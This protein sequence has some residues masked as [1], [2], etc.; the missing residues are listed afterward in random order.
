MATVW[1]F[2]QFTETLRDRVGVSLRRGAALGE[3]SLC[4]SPQ[5][6]ENLRMAAIDASTAIADHPYE[7]KSV[8][9]KFQSVL[10]GSAPCNLWKILSAA[11]HGAAPWRRFRRHLGQ[12]RGTL[13][14]AAKL[15][16][17][18]GG[19]ERLKP[20]V[21]LALVVGLQ[22]ADAGTVGALVVPLKQS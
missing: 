21:L 15:A 18:A 10:D 7:P 22:S 8:A 17:A 16:R 2:G 6:S 9:V 12:K 20:I 11:M 4:Q 19:P 1:P 3:P 13:S 5:S 14:V